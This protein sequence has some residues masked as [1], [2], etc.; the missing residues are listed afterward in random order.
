[1]TVAVVVVVVVVVAVGDVYG[2]Q[3]GLLSI[4]P[5]TATQ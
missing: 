4:Q 3:S 1:V 5:T 2:Q